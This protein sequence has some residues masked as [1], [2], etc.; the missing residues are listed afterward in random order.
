[1][2]PILYNLF[3]KLHAEGILF[4]S[5]Y[6]ANNILT[7]KTHKDIITKANYKLVFPMSIDAKKKKKQ[8]HFS[9]IL[10]NKLSNIVDMMIYF[11]P[12]GFIPGMQSWIDTNN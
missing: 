3:E 6:E 12:I 1:M 9:K 4:D 10:A 11:D 7:T 5:F 8:K 2:V